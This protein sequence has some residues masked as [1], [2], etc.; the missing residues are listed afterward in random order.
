MKSFFLS[1][2]IFCIVIILIVAF[3]NIA[4]VVPGLWILFIM[5]DQQTSAT[6]PIFILIALGF[7][8]G[9]FISALVASIVS[10]KEKEETGGANW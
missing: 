2:T 8:T 10:S 7:I 1:G 5:M 9:I 3:Q 4:T 6:F